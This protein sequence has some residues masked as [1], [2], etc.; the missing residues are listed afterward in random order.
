[1]N[2]KALTPRTALAPEVAKVLKRLH[3]PLDV[4]LLMCVPSY[5]AYGLSLRNLEKMM[6]EC[7]TDVDHSTVHRWAIKLLPVRE[8]PFGVASAKSSGVGAWMRLISRSK[9]SGSTCTGPWTKRETRSISD[10]AAAKRHFEK[11]IERNGAPEAET[12]RQEW[13]KSRCV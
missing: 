1:M 9:D 10:T 5:V 13:G 11:S 2:K 7:G 8:K 4:M 12:E 6:A 3:H